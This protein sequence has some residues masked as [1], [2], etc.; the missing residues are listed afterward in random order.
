MHAQT[1][2]AQRACVLTFLPLG[3]VCLF[4]C[5]WVCFL[6]DPLPCPLSSLTVNLD[7]C[8]LRCFALHIHRVVVMSPRGLPGHTDRYSHLAVTCGEGPRHPPT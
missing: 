3:L 5:A 4:V 8:A 6:I 7:G 2:H 1:T